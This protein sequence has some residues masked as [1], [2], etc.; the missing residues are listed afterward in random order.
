[1]FLNKSASSK[2]NLST[3]SRRI[4]GSDGLTLIELVTVIIL[5][6]II[7]FVAIGAFQIYA[8]K[9][10]KIIISH[11]L[12]EFIRA[13]ED[14]S[15]SN[16]RYLGATGDFIEGGHP[17]IGTL[18]VPEFKFEPSDGVRIEIISGD[19]AHPNNPDSPF[20]AEARHKKTKAKYIFD[21]STH[22]TIEKDE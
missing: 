19:G 4:S 18:S 21:F 15:I 11:D 22:Q 6:V 5:F 3:I 9:A 1:M 14:Y 13:Q 2:K 16:N 17:P 10:Y 8:K 20:K 7:V 12:R